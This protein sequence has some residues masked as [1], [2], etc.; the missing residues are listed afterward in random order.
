MDKKF[1]KQSFCKTPLALRKPQGCLE[2][3]VRA[4]QQE[5]VE[6]F[7]T[8]IWEFYGKNSRDFVWRQTTDPY[9][10]FVSEVMLQQTQTSRVAQKFPC[11]IETFPDFKTLANA[12][13]ADVICAWQGLGYN[14]RALALHQAA[15]NIQDRF[16]GTLP[17]DPLLL[18]ELPGIGPA[19]AASICAFAFNM[20]TVFIETNIRTVFIAHFFPQD[21]VVSDQEIMPLVAQTVD[22]LE[23]RHWYYALMD[24]GVYLKKEL[25]NASQKSKHY[26]KQS[27]FEGSERQIRGMIL[28]ALAKRT[29][30]TLDE[31]YTL[32]DREPSRIQKN[33][34]ELCFEGFLDNYAG[35]YS[36][37]K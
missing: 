37:R 32:I 16:N 23:P 22:K 34:A 33:L 26:A 36:L 4:E 5:S 28:K 8:L 10:I 31:F 9:Q 30:I 6:L 14:R 27:T 3:F 20:P 35:V 18:D 13:C 29:Q 11:F 7:R 15:K 2:G 17:Q 12:S 21:K 1:K 19:T 24:Y 25:G